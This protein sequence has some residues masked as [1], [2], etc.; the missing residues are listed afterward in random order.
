MSQTLIMKRVGAIS[1]F[2]LLGRPHKASG[3]SEIGIHHA[4]A[5][6]EP[7]KGDSGE[8]R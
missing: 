6:L 3:P 2:R 7:A 1:G 5:E 4:G 8:K